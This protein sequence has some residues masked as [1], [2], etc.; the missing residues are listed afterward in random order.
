MKVLITTVPFAEHSELPLDTLRT[1]QIDYFI[2]PLGRRLTESEL[3]EMA[4]EY[5]VIIAGTEPITTKVYRNAPNLKMISRVG[6]G[7]DSVDL[8]E[9]RNRNIKVSY[10]PDAPAPAVAELTLSH[11]MSLLRHTH[12]ANLLMHSGEWH[13][14]AGRRLE[15][16]DIGIIGMG[17]IGTKVANIFSLLGARK[18]HCN[19]IN[20]DTLAALPDRCVVSDIATIQRECDVITLHTP[21][22]PATDN[23]VDQQFLSQLKPSSVIVNTARGQIVDEAALADALENGRIAGA[24]IDVFSFEPYS[25][26]LKNMSKCL[27]SAHMGSMSKDCRAQMEIEATREAVNFILTGKQESPVPEQEYLLQ[28]ANL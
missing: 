3:A 24:A 8:N 27:L 2:N 10:T 16:V 26:A 11:V 14:F 19:D 13:R 7:V 1:N 20:I 28:K 6:I 25:G 15:N 23:F 17:R 18:I 5:D 9:A 4:V 22:T 21:L 12:E